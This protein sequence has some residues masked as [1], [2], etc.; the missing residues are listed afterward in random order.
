[1]LKIELNE[2]PSEYNSLRY[3]GYT[4]YQQMMWKRPDAVG[5]GRGIVQWI[6]DEGYAGWVCHYNGEDGE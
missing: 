1:V 2:G 6:P 5:A 4:Y 3:D